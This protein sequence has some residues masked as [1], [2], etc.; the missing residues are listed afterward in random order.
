VVHF[1]TKVPCCGSQPVQIGPTRVGAPRCPIGLADH[2]DSSR[3]HG[4]GRRWAA[5]DKRVSHVKMGSRGSVLRG[6]SSG[7][8]V[9]PGSL[10][11]TEAGVTSDDNCAPH[12]VAHTVS[13]V[14]SGTRDELPETLDRPVCLQYGLELVALMSTKRTGGR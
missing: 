14:T 8:D 2:P 12:S 4:H 3:N 5:T 13:W 11:V 6:S 7:F 9:A 10:Q 1:H